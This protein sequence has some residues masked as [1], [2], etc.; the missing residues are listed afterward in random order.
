ME[1]RTLGRT[2][3][4]I[5]IVSFG[6]WAI[7]GTWGTVHDRESLAALHTALD[8]G[9]NFFDTADVYGDGRSERLLARLKKERGEPFYVATK[10]GRRLN[11]HTAAGYNRKNLTSF[12]ESSLKNLET[13]A[14]DLLQL[15]CP[16]TEAYYQ[17]EVF[18]ILDDLVTA[19][20]LKFYGVSV[21]KVEEALKAIEFPNVQ[22]VQIIF[23]ILR[24]RPADLFFAR[25]RAR[26]VGIL[27]RVPLASGML[28][29]KFNAASQFEA[30]DHRSFNRN[31]EAFDR[32][33]TFA[34]IDYTTAL[35][36]VDLLR[37]LV[38]QGA[39]M[40]QM[41]LRWI[42]MFPEVTCAIPG[43]KRAEQVRENTKA[44]LLPPLDETIMKQIA[45]IYQEHIR[46]QVHWYW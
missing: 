41:A 40:T 8:C 45:E 20:K 42:L 23:N 3:W 19:G 21:E 39:T 46:D 15:H 22:T 44:A 36:A 24:Q 14:I 7:G 13:E 32:G 18:G 26:Q 2:G 34:G 17:P 31:G 43:A 37:L 9:V 6:A 35:K 1:Y 16:P 4:K 5:S 10:A 25:A 27:S 12:V 11:P 30:D 38:P 33:E 29:G 28:T